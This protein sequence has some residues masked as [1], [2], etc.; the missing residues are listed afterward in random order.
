VESV[1]AIRFRYEASEEHYVSPR[2][3]S[4]RCPK[5]GSSLVELE[6]RKLLC[7]SCNRIEDRDDV[8]AMNIMACEVPQARPSG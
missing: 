1:K 7:P 3:T 5:C 2:G 6:G 8:A 4:R